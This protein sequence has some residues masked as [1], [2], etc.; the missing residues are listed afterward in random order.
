MPD[1]LISTSSEN[2]HVTALGI[3]ADTSTRGVDLAG[4]VVTAR[5]ADGSSETAIW[6]ALDPYTFGAVTGA[7]FEIVFGF[8]KHELTVTKRLVALEF[9]VA[10]ASSVFDIDPALDTDPHGGSTPS[11]SNGFPFRVDPAFEGVE[12]DIE[13]TYS[14]I[15]R[16]A[17]FAA[18]G[19]LFTRMSVDFS[20]L[21]DGG[22]LGRLD[23]NSDIDTMRIAGDLRPEAQLHEG[24]ALGDV[25]TGS[26]A[27]EI[28]AG[29]AGDDDIE[30]GAGNDILVGGAG[31]DTLDGGA[32]VDTAAFVAALSDVTLQFRADGSTVVMD[33]DG[34]GEG[35]DVLTGIEWLD[36]DGGARLQLDKLDGIA[37]LATAEVDMLIEVYIAYF[38]RAPDAL[39]LYFW[40]NAYAD[41][42]PLEQ[43]AALFL[44]QDETRETYPE[45][46]STLDFVTQVYSNVL[47]RVPDAGGLS[48]WEGKLDS[49]EVSRDVFILEVLRGAK[50]TPPGADQEV[51]DLQLAD[52]AY[53]ATKTDIG[54][55]FAAIRGL[56]NVEDAGEAMEAFV[57]GQQ[58]TVDSAVALIDQFYADASV[59]EGGETLMQLVGVVADPLADL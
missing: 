30:A 41:G 3:R 9:D 35:A 17:G 14:G 8:E 19:D 1:V 46:L 6:R 11:S 45:T 4:A 40:G 18:E 37:G 49:G 59:A 24:G 20:G 51:I 22:L 56:S 10:P 33:R 27:D 50:V 26:A 5:Y 47:G 42:I 48:F 53:L 15:T 29:L 32:G 36:F 16:L 23:W 13:V 43:I 39:G 54:T 21:A 44:D 7:D 55:Y 31:D 52:R 28:L 34:Q 57:R 58:A 2:P 12:G 25:L 38:N